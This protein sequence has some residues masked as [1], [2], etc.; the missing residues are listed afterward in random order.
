MLYGRGTEQDQIH[1]MLVRAGDGA[2]GALVIHGEA[3]IGKTALLEYASGVAGPGRV[4]RTVGI[5]SEMELAFGGLHQLLWPVAGH[6]DRLPRP[7]AAVLSA[8]L[9]VSGEAVRDRFGLGTAVLAILSQ[10]AAGGPLLCLVD[11]SQW[12]DRA[13]L[14]ALVFAARRLHAEGVVMLFAVRDGVPGGRSTACRSCCCRG[15]TPRPSMPCSP[16]GWSPCRPTRGSRS[17]SRRRATR[18]PCWNCPR[19]SPPNSGAAS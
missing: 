2:S 13:S 17:S 15:S 19:R 5:E 18:W 10:A 9:G 1:R 16:A 4:L 7:Q 12:L 3:G 11:D 14:D 8:A 6:L